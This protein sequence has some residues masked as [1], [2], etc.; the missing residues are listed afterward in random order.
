MYVR[1]TQI[2]E[3]KRVIT[4]LIFFLKLILRCVGPRNSGN[5]SIINGSALLRDNPFTIPCHFLCISGTSQHAL[6]ELF[7]V[8]LAAD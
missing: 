6:L 4:R 5:V 2:E 3:I 7:E 1:S 8:L